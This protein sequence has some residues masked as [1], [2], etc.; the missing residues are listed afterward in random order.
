MEFNKKYLVRLR[1][2]MA[3][4][5]LKSY[6]V[7][8][9]DPHSSEEPAEY[10]R[11]ERAALCPFTGDNA[12]LLVLENEAYLW[13]DGR[14]FIS[15]EKELSGSD[16][17]MMKMDTKGYPDIEEFLKEENCF[18]LGTNFSVLPFNFYEK[19][20][21]IGKVIDYRFSKLLDKRTPL[22]DS[23]L[24]DFDKEEF[25][26]YSAAEKIDLIQEDLIKERLDGYLF[27][28]LDDIAWITNFRGNDVPFTPLFYSFLFIPA[29]GDVHLFVNPTRVENELEGF[30]IHPYEEIAAFL[31]ERK[32]E[33][34]GVDKAI[35]NAELGSILQNSVDMLSPAMLKKAIK[36]EVEIKNIIRA[37][38]EDGVALLKFIYFLY[39]NS[40]KKISELELAKIL[41]NFRKE[42]PH[43]LYDSFQPIV[44]V[45]GN[46]A[47][48]H[49]AP[50]EKDFSY[51]NYDTLE[52]LVDSGGQYFGGTTDTT[53]TFLLGEPTD[54]YIHDYT[55]TLKSLIALSKARFIDGT[56]G[57]PLDMLARNIMWREGL[58]YKCGTG[59]GVGYLS[60]VHEGPNSFRYKSKTPYS[61]K[62]DLP[63]VPGNVTTVEPGVYKEGKYGIRIENNLLTVEDQVTSDGTFYKFETI[64][65]VPIELKAVDFSLLDKEEVDW[66]ISYHKSVYKHLSKYVDGNL[67]KFLRDLTLP[68]LKDVKKILLVRNPKCE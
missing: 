61:A 54:E 40:T 32:T 46:A 65:Y 49:Y 42:N 22:C 63:N 27:S 11:D 29:E 8:T 47:M 3:K 35:I 56:T 12:L 25:Q 26:K 1:E 28:S 67:K 59:H 51:V 18:P 62:L 45:N 48:M 6:L 20:K 10:F 58:D 53:R 5:G 30:V 16:I 17:K 50:S 52:L 57:K 14:F 55:L 13:V 44:A 31:E 64:T 24:I 4:N 36:N 23:K 37:Q 15:A 43:Y 41:T 9:G 68:V 19:L 34:I 66:I 7:V 39:S 38:E 33:V 21:E 60:V 2:E